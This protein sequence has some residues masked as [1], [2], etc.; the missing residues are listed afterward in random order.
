MHLVAELEHEHFKQRARAANSAQAARD[1]H[2]Y[3]CEIHVFVTRA[4]EAA[5]AQ[6][7]PPMVS[8]PK[9]VPPNEEC[10][11]AFTADAL[12]QALMAPTVPS[13]QLT[14]S[15]RSVAN[16]PTNGQR[17]PNNLQDVWVWKGRPDWEQVFAM[18]QQQAVD[19]DIGVFVRAKHPTRGPVLALRVN[20]TPAFFLF[21][22][23]FFFPLSLTF[24]LLSLSFS[25]V[26][27]PFSSAAQR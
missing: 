13:R 26:F 2:R 16:G 6:P 19:P 11:P 14:E 15:M 20:K 24:R 8:P 7:L 10:K 12:Y 27:V 5:H 1:W 25:I 21:V 18:M 17:P 3:Y 22:F 23:L 9:F 4:P